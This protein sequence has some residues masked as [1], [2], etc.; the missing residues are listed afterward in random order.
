MMP[1]AVPQPVICLAEL[2]LE[3]M[4]EPDLDTVMAIEASSHRHPWSRGNFIDSIQAGHWAYCLREVSD[5]GKRIWAY[6]I[7]LPA[8]DDLHLL[9]ITVDTDLRGQGVGLRLMSAIQAIASNLSIPRIL[10][11]VRPSNE[12]AIALYEK[13]GYEELARRKAYYP[14]ESSSGIREDAIVMVKNI[15]CSV[16]PY[17]H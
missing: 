14:V 3:L 8:V 4:T 9:N 6:C 2:V 5:P 17:A 16:K 12:A 13:A 15:D 1:P 10:L 11:E 7:L